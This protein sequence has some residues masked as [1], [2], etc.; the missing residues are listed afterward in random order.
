[1]LNTYTGENLNTPKKSE[2]TWKKVISVTFLFTENKP[3]NN[4][5]NN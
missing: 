5:I 1:M 3:F 2:H 4:S